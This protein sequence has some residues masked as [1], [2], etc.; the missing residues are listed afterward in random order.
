MTSRDEFDRELRLAAMGWLTQRTQDGLESITAEALEEFTFR[1]EQIR[2]KDRQAGIWKPRQL[3][4]AL[5]V[6]TAY[7]K[8]VGARPYNDGAGPDGLLRYK[9]RGDDPQHFQNRALRVAMRQEQP[10]IWFFG[11]GSGVYQPVYPLYIV[12]EEPD[13]QQFVLAPDE[14]RG[15]VKVGSPIEEQLRRYVSREVKQR[16]HQPVFRGMVMRAYETSC[17]VCSLR[18]TELLDAAHIVPDSEEAG[19]ASVTNGLALCKI[20]HAAFDQQILGIRP[21]NFTVEIRKD[22]LEEVDGPMLRHGLQERHGQQLM[23][24]PRSRAE[25]PDQELLGISYERFRAAG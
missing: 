22:L 16:L 3:D 20:H 12:D 7:P 17:A 4:S 6:F 19:V 18:H 2:L 14:L 15:V 10:L 1:G 23:V 21:D 11:V 9:W 13:L 24:L 5:S 25:R 8:K